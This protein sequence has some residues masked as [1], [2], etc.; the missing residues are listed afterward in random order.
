[1]KKIVLMLGIVIGVA[2]YAGNAFS[3]CVG[4]TENAAGVDDKTG[5]NCGIC[6]TNCN[7]ILEGE[8]L[9]ITGGA[10]GTI[11]NMRYFGYS[12]T[13]EGRY[14]YLT[15]A[16]WKDM[17]V[18]SV[19]I[20][21]INKIGDFAFMGM[22]ISEVKFD[23][24]VTYISQDAFWGNNLSTLEL[25]DSIET[26][27]FGALAYSTSANIDT[28]ALPDSLSSIG[29]FALNFG[30]DTIIIPDTVTEIQ[31]AAFAGNPN[32]ICKGSKSSCQNLKNILSEYCPDYFHCSEGYYKDL[33]KNMS[34]SGYETCP[35]TNYF[36]NGDYCVREPDLSKRKCC[37]VCKDID[38]YCSRIRY[39][40]PEADEITSNDNENMIEWIFE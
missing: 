31:A 1:M 21:G 3:V 8:K 5:A 10:D 7:W 24:N 35:S 36:W 18:S 27:S 40:L 34:I 6:G 32:I 16:P 13:D 25:P 37:D 28:L 38:G 30:V 14:K 22:G 33:S 4:A 23:N 19:D 20:Q 9:K 11:G 39:T 12:E 29:N 17:T 2:L 26:L 15:N